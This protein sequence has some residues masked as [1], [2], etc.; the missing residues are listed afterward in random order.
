MARVRG[1]VDEL[2]IK[3]RHVGMGAKAKVMRLATGRVR[4]TGSA[5]GGGTIE[6]YF[7]VPIEKAGFDLFDEVSFE[8]EKVQTTGEGRKVGVAKNIKRI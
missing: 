4:A 3:T 2:F 7:E 6:Y 1:R 5:T 8:V